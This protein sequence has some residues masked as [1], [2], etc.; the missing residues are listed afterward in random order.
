M[1]PADRLFSYFPLM[2]TVASLTALGVFAQWPSLWSAALL[3]FVIYFMPP[4]VQRI[5]FRW[6]PLKHGISPID[7][8]T[9]SP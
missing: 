6:A 4:M 1:T 3:I 9:F 8:R 2:M 5:M 7:G